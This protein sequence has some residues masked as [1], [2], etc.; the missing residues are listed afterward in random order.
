ME[1][2]DFQ[3]PNVD[4]GTFQEEWDNADNNV[5]ENIFRNSEKHQAEVH[6]NV[7]QS[8]ESLPSK[9]GKTKTKRA[10]SPLPETET[11][12]SPVV[13]NAGGFS[14]NIKDISLQNPEF[15]KILWKKKIS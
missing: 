1:N 4:F 6:N 3:L 15:R 5:S 12:E 9:P 10:R 11:G 14:G 13:S 2:P 7:E 8:D